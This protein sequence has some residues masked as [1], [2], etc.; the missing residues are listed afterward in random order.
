[1]KQNET[2]SPLRL[3]K[4]SKQHS[5]P[6]KWTKTVNDYNNYIKEYIKHYKKALKG[7]SNSLIRYP[8]LKAK[9]ESLGKRL[10]KAQKQ[11]ML[12]EKQVQKILRIQ[13]KIIN[14]CYE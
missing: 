3:S 8:Y 14:A 10:G 1:M 7:N 12:T 4:I 9:S 6:D 11:G 2:K 13:L 5:I